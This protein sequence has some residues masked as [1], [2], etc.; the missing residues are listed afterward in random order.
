[1]A[2]LTQ[3]E[4]EA[5]RIGA[6]WPSEAEI[7]STTTPAMSGI[8]GHTVNFEKGCYTGQEFVARVHYR[9]AAP[10]RRLVQIVFEPGSAVAVGADVMVDGEPAGMVTSAVGEAG[11]GLGY[12]KR[13]IEMP[14]EGVVGPIAVALS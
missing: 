2:A 3:N 12:C 14:A 9:D 10:P 11:V 5:I 8:V 4:L 1:M 7:D 6:N 13:S